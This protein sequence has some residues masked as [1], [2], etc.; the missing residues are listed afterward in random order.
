MG[1]MALMKFSKPGYFIPFLSKGEWKN[2]VGRESVLV[3][4]TSQIN[5]NGNVQSY[6]FSDAAHHYY[7]YSQLF[8]SY[9]PSL[10]L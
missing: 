3:N 2:S 10:T 4:C 7:I 5:Y 8:D 1:Y 6:E 9:T